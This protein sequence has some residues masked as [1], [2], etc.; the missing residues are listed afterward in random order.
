VNLFFGREQFKVGPINEIRPG[1]NRVGSHAYDT[2]V[3]NGLAVLRTRD[4]FF[5]TLRYT[6]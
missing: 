5:T 6:F 4:E 1:L 3:E 2:G